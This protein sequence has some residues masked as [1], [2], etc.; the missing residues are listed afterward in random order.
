MLDGISGNIEGAGI[1]IAVT[2]TWGPALTRHLEEFL[3]KAAD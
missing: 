1:L 3:R 2:F